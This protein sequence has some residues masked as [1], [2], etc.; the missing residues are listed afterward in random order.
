MYFQAV[1]TRQQSATTRYSKQ[2]FFI[3]V[4]EVLSNKYFSDKLDRSFFKL[5][6][7]F[8]IKKRCIELYCLRCRPP[9]KSPV[10]TSSSSLSRCRVAGPAATQAYELYGITTL[11]KSLRRLF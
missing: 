7:F 2:L 9:S 4:G 5:Y 3:F 10:Q 1:L 11:N 6:L 8:H